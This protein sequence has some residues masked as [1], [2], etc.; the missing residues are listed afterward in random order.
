MTE[1]LEHLEPGMPIIY[2]GDK[3]TRVS[4]ELAETFMS[5]DRL[6]V[7]QETGDLLHIPAADWDRAC[8]AVTAASDAF[9]TMGTVT[10]NQIAAF[11]E[12]F[13]GYLAD[14]DVFAVIASANTADLERANS[15]GR[16]T[17]RLTLTEGM[18]SDMIQGL[19]MWAGADGGRGDVMATFDHEGWSLD[20]VRSGLGVVAF[21]FEGRPNVF[22]DA[23][24]VL[25]GGNTVV[26][27]IG[28]DALGTARAI[29]ENA[30]RPALKDAGLPQGA[31]SLVDASSHA[32][33]WAMFSDPRLGLAVAR[34]SGA[35]VS[36]LGS[37]ARQ[38]GIPVS[39]HGTGGAWIVAAESAESSN[40]AAAIYNSLDRK[41]CNTLNTA[42]V[43]ASRAEDLIPV[44]LGALHRA[45]ERRSAVS[46]LHVTAQARPFV[47]DVWFEPAPITR[48]EGVVTE[49]RA[50]MIDDEAL[51]VEWESAP[52]EPGVVGAKREALDAYA[53]QLTNLTGESEWW[54]LDDPFLGHFLGP[55]EVHLPVRRS[56]RRRRPAGRAGPARARWS[57]P[58]SRS[59]RRGRPASSGAAGEAPAPAASARWPAACPAPRAG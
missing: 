24:G 57:G 17:T 32:A 7:V 5:G 59:S 6:V 36:Q 28:S 26:L 41:V 22:A 23:T 30:L 37:V 35:A 13:A 58:G 11:F 43:V 20:Q 27:R 4:P 10:D 34:G 42:C 38:A 19:L 46:K 54:T 50:E 1:S 16:S 40:F 9:A 2:G 45:G 53:S 3:V 25:I 31:V 49:P 21:V 14:D 51:S 56:S 33:G 39:L 29:M 52:L 47:P 12:E 55:Y 15:R 44:F 48:A 18:R 8:Q